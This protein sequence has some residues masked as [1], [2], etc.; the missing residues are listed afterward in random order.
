MQAPNISCFPRRLQRN[1]FRLPRRLEDVFKTYLR[2]IFL[3]RL[4]DVFKRSSKT[5]SRPFQDVFARHLAIMSWRRLQY[6]FTKTNVCWER[7]YISERIQKFFNLSTEPVE[8]VNIST[9]R[10]SQT[11]SKSIDR[12][13]L[14]AKT[15][16]HE[17]MLI[18]VLCLPMLCLPISSPS[19]TFLK[20][21]SEKFHRIEFVGE[22]S[23]KDIGLLIGSD[24]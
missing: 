8:D 14:V 16:N 24:L 7:T 5:F 4:Q 21:Q 19:I 9:F 22:D 17:N 18:K 11:L 10:N 1:T 15:N 6:V 2:Y 20:G 12:V 13:S 3:K 23:E